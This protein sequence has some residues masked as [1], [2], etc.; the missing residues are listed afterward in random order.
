MTHVT[1]DNGA[2]TLR[3]RPTP[4]PRRAHLFLGAAPWTPTT[5]DR[6]RASAPT[7]PTSAPTTPRVR[8]LIR[9]AAVCMVLLLDLVR[10]P[11]RPSPR[12]A[13]ERPACSIDGGKPT[14]THRLAHRVPPN[15]PL[16][17]T[18]SLQRGQRRLPEH[19][20]MLLCRRCSQ[21]AAL[22]W[23][24][25]GWRFDGQVHLCLIRPENLGY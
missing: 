24:R 7:T 21:A 10:P 13:L 18:Q 25:F 20:G 23:R 16:P 15:P 14:T 9:R 3:L 8:R 2:R 5:G 12:C 11:R 4:P 19:D 6:T 17:P 1:L 22:V